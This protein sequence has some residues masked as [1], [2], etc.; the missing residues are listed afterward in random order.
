MHDLSSE[1]RSACIIVGVDGSECSKTALRWAISQARLTGASVEAFAAWQDPVMYGYAYGW[2]PT[3]F[4]GSDSLQAITEKTLAETVAGVAGSGGQAVTIRTRVV[5][6]HPTQVL[7]D[8]A[9]GAQMLVV[10][11]R[12]HG[13]FAGILLGSVSQHCVQHAP[14]PVT[15]I[16]Q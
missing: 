14:C 7:M 4:A 12:G 10:G 6:G 16:P 15:V 1:Q 8:A 2:A 13:T 9:T 11:S 5:Q 3:S